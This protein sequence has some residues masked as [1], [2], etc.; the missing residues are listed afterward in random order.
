MSSS[1]VVAGSAAAAAARAIQ[2]SVSP[3]GRAASLRSSM[4]LRVLKAFILEHDLKVMKHQMIAHDKAAQQSGGLPDP[5]DPDAVK[6]FFDRLDRARAQGPVDKTTTEQRAVLEQYVRDHGLSAS[7]AP[8]PA[9]TPADLAAAIAD[10]VNLLPPE[11]RMHALADELKR[12]PAERR[13]EALSELSRLLPWFQ[14]LMQQAVQQTI[15][16]V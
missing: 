15:D 4:E 12:L 2:L 14:P 8:G 13:P 1:P 6:A 9:A 5:S 11:R 3:S 16:K 10:R 7:A